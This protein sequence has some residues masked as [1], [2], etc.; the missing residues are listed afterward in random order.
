MLPER[1]SGNC[2]L[3]WLGEANSIGIAALFTVR[4]DSPRAVGSRISEVTMLIALKLAPNTE[5]REPGATGEIRSA[6]LTTLAGEGDD[7]G[8]DGHRQSRKTGNGER[9]DRIP[10]HQRR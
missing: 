6:A 2:A 3:I 1:V 4:Q 7:R 10:V 8:L 9:N 5:I